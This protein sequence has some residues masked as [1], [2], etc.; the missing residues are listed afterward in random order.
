MPIY[1]YVCKPCG[2][3]FEKYH[4][5]MDAPKPACPECGK[6]RGVSRAIA[7]YSFIKDENTKMAEM[8]PKYAKKVD[9]VWD[10]AV[11]ADPLS[12]SRFGRDIDSGRRVQ[13]L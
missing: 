2:A 1:E 5:S 8:H 7:G 4:K 12:T 3:G 13:D 11:K 6:K 9:A 10:A